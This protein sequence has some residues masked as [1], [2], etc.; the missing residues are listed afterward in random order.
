MTFSFQ[1]DRQLADMLMP[2]RLEQEVLGSL[3]CCTATSAAIFY[4]TVWPDAMTRIWT[5]STRYTSWRNSASTIIISH[6]F[7]IHFSWSFRS[8]SIPKPNLNSSSHSHVSLRPPR[9]LSRR[10]RRFVDFPKHGPYHY[11]W[12]DI[13]AFTPSHWRGSLSQISV[14]A[15]VF[16]LVKFSSKHP[17]CV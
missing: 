4:E 10:R 9:T 6:D 7:L 17:Q 8:H 11:V 2:S 5:A 12:T 13:R 1:F 15:L 14:S 16:V 3:F